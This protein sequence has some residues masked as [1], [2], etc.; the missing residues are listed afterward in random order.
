[1]TGLRM[2]IF[3][4]CGYCQPS[5]RAGGVQAGHPRQYSCSPGGGWHHHWFLFLQK[6][7]LV[8]FLL[9]LNCHIQTLSIADTISSF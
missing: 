1:M 5:A 2:I 9:S 3:R 4:L 8:I 6:R 7:Y